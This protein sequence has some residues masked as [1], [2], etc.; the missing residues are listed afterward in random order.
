M[1]P[2]AVSRYARGRHEP[3]LHYLRYGEHEGRG[4]IWYFDAPGI[5]VYNIPPDALALAHFLTAHTGHFAP[6][7]ELWAVLYLAPY[8][9][10][11]N[12]GDDPFAHYL[13][14]MVRS[15]ANRFRT[16]GSSAASGLVDPNYYLI[17]GADV[18][19]AQIGSGRAFL[20]LRW[21]EGRKPNIYFDTR[22]YLRPTHLAQAEDQ[23]G[24]ALHS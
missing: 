3:L 11:P 15:G 24:G 20:P 13:D 6:M 16:W 21:R 4:P 2:G 23:S 18:Q 7:A 9:D 5:A 10:D 1:V 12:A 22:W 8:C 19:E 14:D 17:N